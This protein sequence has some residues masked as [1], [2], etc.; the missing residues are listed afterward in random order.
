M[1][2][3][4]GYCKTPI[5]PLLTPLQPKIRMSDGQI[6][7]DFMTCPCIYTWAFHL[8]QSCPNCLVIETRSK[9]RGPFYMH[10]TQTKNYTEYKAESSSL[11]NRMAK[12]K[13]VALI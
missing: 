12:R 3:T 11:G 7:P 10:R 13:N 9:P 4:C 1:D 6:P 5:F 2:Q 8:L